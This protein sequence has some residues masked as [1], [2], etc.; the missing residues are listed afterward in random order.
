MIYQIVV[1]GNRLEWDNKWHLA[2]QKETFS[3][4]IKNA[5]MVNKT[6]KIR[7]SLRDFQ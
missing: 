4:L 3:D 7:K 5:S 2:K 6:I 1:R